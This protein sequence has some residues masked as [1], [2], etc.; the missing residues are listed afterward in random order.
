MRE[1]KFKHKLGDFGVCHTH[2]QREYPRDCPWCEFVQEM[3]R[4][5]VLN[6]E[7]NR[8]MAAL[9]SI[10]SH[11]INPDTSVENPEATALK[12]IASKAYHSNEGETEWEVIA[13][14]LDRVEMLEGLLANVHDELHDPMGQYWGDQPGS[15]RELLEALRDRIDRAMGWME[16]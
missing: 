9:W 1:D 5:H 2:L 16:D 15:D 4:N 10:I 11:P 13:P 6:S 12:H 7:R 3:R 14:T 8:L